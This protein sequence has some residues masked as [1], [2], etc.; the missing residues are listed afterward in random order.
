MFLNVVAWKVKYVLKDEVC[1]IKWFSYY[2]RGRWSL[3]DFK[4]V[5]I[6]KLNMRYGFL[7]NW[8][9]KIVEIKVME[10]IDNDNIDDIIDKCLEVDFVG[11]MC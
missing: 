4:F 2:V 7:C 11:G 1:V 5:L 8:K 6:S 3:F 9:L 10:Y